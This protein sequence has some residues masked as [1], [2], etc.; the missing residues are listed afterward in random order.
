MAAEVLASVLVPVLDEERHLPEVAR[1]MLGQQA[2][3][4]LE[5]LFI[6]GGSSDGTVAAVEA[7]ARLDPRVRLLHNPA[8]I[9]PVALNLGLRAARGRYVVRMDAHT[10]YRDDYIARGVERLRR[11]DVAHVSGAQLP[12]GYDAGSELMVKALSSRLGVGGAAFRTATSETEVDSGFLGVWERELLLAH[13]GWDEG[14]V[15]NQDGE[16]AARIRAAGGRIVC[17]PEMAAWYL[18]RNSLRT[19]ARQYFGYGRYRARTSV[20]HPG[21]VRPAHV[22]PPGVAATLLVAPKLRLARLGLA[23][24]AAAILAEAL[25]LRDPRVAGV[26]AAM[27]LSW[28]YGFLVGLA[29]FHD[30]SRKS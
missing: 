22:L 5:F 27:H 2:G 13:G 6:D 9:T 4:E 20:K 16:L 15:R 25:R 12:R 17:I 18:P 23:A 14:Q 24:Y 3:G 11:G 10:H 29:Q 8:R 30:V 28:G 1:Q 21:S 19:V 7:L 26:F